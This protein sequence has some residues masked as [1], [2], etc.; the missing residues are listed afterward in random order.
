MNHNVMRR[1]KQ[2]EIFYLGVCVIPEYPRCEIEENTQTSL[3]C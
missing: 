3:L 2:G 1:L